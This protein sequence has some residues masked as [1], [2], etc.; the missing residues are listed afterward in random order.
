MDHEILV[1]IMKRLDVLMLI[2]STCFVCK[3]WLNATLDALFP[4]HHVF[5]MRHYPL[6][7]STSYT[8][9]RNRFWTMIQLHLNRNLPTQHYYTKLVLTQRTLT[10]S[11]YRYIAQR[12]PSITSL[13]LDIGMH[14]L[15]SFRDFPP[16]WKE[17]VE[18]ECDA[19]CVRVIGLLWNQI[20]TLRLRLYGDVKARDAISI[21]NDFPCLTHLSLKN[22]KLSDNALSLI[23]EGQKN[24]TYLDMTHARLGEK[25][26]AKDWDEDLLLKASKIPQFLRCEMGNCSSCFP[27]YR[28]L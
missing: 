2:L 26:D 13:T 9:S 27:C 8:L 20:H 19:S 10:T 7:N 17:L 18:V 1:S 12:L 4:P 23:L 16:C 14:K 28:P 22:C 21:A 25:K 24:L 3:S 5:D 11:A 6:L 15:L